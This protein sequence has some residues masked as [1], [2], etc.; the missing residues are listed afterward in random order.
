MFFG[1]KPD[2]AYELLPTHQ[3]GKLRTYGDGNTKYAMNKK[4]MEKLAD[5]KGR[6][7]Y[8]DE[9]KKIV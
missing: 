5:K 2:N 9:S 4:R 1:V 8:Y 7:V 6:D 3:F